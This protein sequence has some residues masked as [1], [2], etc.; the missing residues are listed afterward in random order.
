M[1]VLAHQPGCAGAAVQAGDALT[2]GQ[3]HRTVFAAET[4]VAL[5]V[6]VGDVIW[7]HC[8]ISIINLQAISIRQKSKKK[9]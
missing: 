4:W 8:E 3:S 7:N 2:A 6:V 9:I 1:V 5:A